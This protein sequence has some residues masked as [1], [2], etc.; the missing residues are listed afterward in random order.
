MWPVRPQPGSTDLQAKMDAMMG[1]DAAPAAPDPSSL[2]AQPAGG[3]S[4]VAEADGDGDGDGDGP[5]SRLPRELVD[6]VLLQLAY[7]ASKPYVA[8]SLLVLSTS[9]HRLLLPVIYTHPILASAQAI[10]RLARTLR[11]SPHLGLLVR[12]L[13]LRCEFWAGGID[14]NHVVQILSSVANAT[15]IVLGEL[16]APLAS[17]LPADAKVESLAVRV[18]PTASDVDTLP[19]SVSDAPWWHRIKHLG[20]IFDDTVNIL[21]RPPRGLASCTSFTLR[22]PGTPVGIAVKCNRQGAI[23]AAMPDEFAAISPSRG[24]TGDRPRNVNTDL[25]R[26]LSEEEESYVVRSAHTDLALPLPGIRCRPELHPGSE[27]AGLRR[28]LCSQLAQVWD[29]RLRAS[30]GYESMRSSGPDPIRFAVE[31]D[32]SMADRR[33]V[34]AEVRA[35]KVKHGL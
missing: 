11:D 35:F 29:H 31:L 34:A 4:T 7:T 25:D 32:F 33:S 3:A 13:Y 12:A 18:R 1:F 19:P 6:E 21:R 2:S 8:Q 10:V 22:A 30:P 9:I 23:E 28:C 5:W 20:L 15:D 26:S 17:Y 24:R 27:V 14:E 16:E